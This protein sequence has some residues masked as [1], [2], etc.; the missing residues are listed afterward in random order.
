MILFLILLIPSVSGITFFTD[1][2]ATL[3]AACKNQSYVESTANI[4]IWYPNSSLWIA[5]ETMTPITLGRFNYTFIAPGVEGNYLSSVLCTIGG[6]EGYDEDDFWVRQA[7]E[8]MTS[9]A[10]VIF[11]M[12]IT[13]GVF[14][15]PRFF[16]ANNKYLDFTLK[17]LCIIFGLFLLSLDAVIVVTVADKANL[18]ISSEI[19]TYLWI[20]NWATYLA[21]VIVILSFGY[22]MLQMWKI[23]KHNKRMGIDPNE[24]E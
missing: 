1:S 20:I 10:V 6:I 19:F 8:E 22:K 21:M 17:G 5:N 9:M 13:I 24:Q 7:E 18:G 12:L 3:W 15:A 23:D 2:E 11:I 4:S 14:I 16:K